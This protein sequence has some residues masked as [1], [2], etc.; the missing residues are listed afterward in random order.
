MID[1]IKYTVSDFGDAVE[2][3]FLDHLERAEES[4]LVKRQ[5]FEKMSDVSDNNTDS[6]EAVLLQSDYII[7]VCSLVDML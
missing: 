5:A 2:D 6:V 4:I 3:A 1:K 7:S